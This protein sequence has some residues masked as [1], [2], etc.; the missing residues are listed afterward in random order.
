MRDNASHRS[1]MEAHDA[2]SREANPRIPLDEFARGRR[3]R[4]HFDGVTLPRYVAPGRAADPPRWTEAGLPPGRTR[5]VAVAPTAREWRNM[6]EKGSRHFA[7]PP[8]THLPKAASLDK[9]E[10][11]KNGLIVRFCDLALPV[12]FCG[13]AVVGSLPWLA[14]RGLPVRSRHGYSI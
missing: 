13:L 6:N 4:R 3:V 1:M 2:I 8:S 9:E 7:V 12:F 5:S 11:R 14:L 10:K